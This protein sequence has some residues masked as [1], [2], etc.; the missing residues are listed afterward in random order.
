MDVKPYIETMKTEINSL[1]SSAK[2]G[3]ILKE[4][5]K[6]KKDKHAAQDWKYEQRV[7]VSVMGIM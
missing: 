3:Y 4:R 1:K 2:L 6:E 5:N 7:E